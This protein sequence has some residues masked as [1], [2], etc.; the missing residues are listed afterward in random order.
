MI[1]DIRRDLEGWLGET[2]F[3]AVRHTDPT[4][5]V[6]RHPQALA[7][8]SEDAAN[9]AVVAAEAKG[10]PV[11]LRRHRALRAGIAWARLDAAER[12]GALDADQRLSQSAARLPDGT[13]AAWAAL[14]ELRDR[15]PLR[16]AR[17]AGERAMAEAAG[18]IADLRREMTRRR[19]E[20]AQRRGE[21]DERGVFERLDGVDLAK[22]AAEAHRFLDTTRDAWTD[23]ADWLLRRHGATLD[24]AGDHDLAWARFDFRHTLP[25]PRDRMVKSLEG[26]LKSMGIDGSGG[27][28]V[29]RGIAATPGCIVARRQV[30]GEIHLLLHLDDGVPAWMEA[31]SAWGRALAAAWT[32]AALPMEDRVLGDRAVP[33]TWGALF[34]LVPLEREW[35]VRVLDCGNSKDAARELEILHLASVRRLAGMLE[36]EIDLAA[37][38]SPR[39]AAER[40][41]AATGARFQEGL[42][43]EESSNWFG[44]AHRLRAAAAAA[45]LAALLRKKCEDWH[46]SASMGNFLLE[47]WSYGRQCGTAELLEKLGADKDTFGAMAKRFLE[48]L[49]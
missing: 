9:D 23:N 16:E 6:T 25:A 49:A 10:D 15:S 47:A 46:R 7:A 12:E 29:R 40:I 26:T 31:L 28:R 4:L 2:E 8:A 18:S 33:F 35:I 42:L 45:S 13:R 38:A 1:A 41:T 37:G 32:P 34:A 27:G 19:R 36:A 5:R 3:A 14:R 24:T 48:R 30:P 21:R 44:S 39:E 17:A 20:E 11:L 43:L 22:L